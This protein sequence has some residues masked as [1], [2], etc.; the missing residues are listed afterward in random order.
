[1]RG[2]K[3]IGSILLLAYFPVVT[4][5]DITV[6]RGGY[7]DIN[8]GYSKVFASDYL[9]DV[10]GLG[11]NFNLG[12]K[13]M[14]FFAFEMGYTTYGASKSSFTG[15]NAID[16]A[17]KG[18]IPFVEVGMEIFAK[19]GPVYVVN[20]K[21]PD[22]VSNHTTNVYYGFGGAYAWS[23][24]MLVTLQWAQASGNSNTGNFQLL[25]IGAT[26]IF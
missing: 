9:E 23:P 13:M 5:A 21:L 14:P 10:M 3:K 8:V 15:A 7:G 25:S 18:I 4:F 16:A 17:L 2:I 20:S 24:T 19:I 11:L 22:D 1:M 26:Y 12:Y 6:A